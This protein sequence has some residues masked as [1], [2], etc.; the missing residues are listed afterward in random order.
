M[1]YIHFITII[2]TNFIIIDKEIDKKS[3]KQKKQQ[4]DI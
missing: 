1:I 3:K 4:L 2:N